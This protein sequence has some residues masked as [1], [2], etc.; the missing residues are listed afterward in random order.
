MRI[1][2]FEPPFL[3]LKGRRTV[4]FPLGPGYLAAALAEHGHE[5]LIHNCEL[6]TEPPMAA[7]DGRGSYATLFAEH[8]RYRD[9]LTGDDHPVWREVREEIARH[10]PEIVGITV[11]SAK[12]PAALRI[13]TIAKRT[14]PG[15][16]WFLNA[17]PADLF[18]A[19][20]SI[21]LLKGGI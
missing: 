12:L 8:H 3:R 13:A 2:L 18:Q 19:F 14:A 16:R 9:A 1:L 4:F 7:G 17:A 15:C 11:R 10:A 5:V 6:M 20:V 21:H